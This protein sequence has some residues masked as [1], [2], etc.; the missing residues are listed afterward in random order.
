MKTSLRQ[1]AT[2]QH[3]SRPRG[4]RR[5]PFPNSCIAAIVSYS[6]T[7]PTLTSSA[8]DVIRHPGL[9]RQSGAKLSAA[10]R[11]RHSLRGARVRQALATPGTDRIGYNRRLIARTGPALCGI[12]LGDA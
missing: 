1:A 12:V 10:K 8:G 4:N 2:P 5:G 3:R 11:L 9:R 7:S 6:I